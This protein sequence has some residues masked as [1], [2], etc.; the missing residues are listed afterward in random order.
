[1]D[2]ELKR[3]RLKEM[4]KTALDCLDG[5]LSARSKCLTITTHEYFSNLATI[6][7][8][9]LASTLIEGGWKCGKGCRGNREMGSILDSGLRIKIGN[10]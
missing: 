7:I 10:T 9:D 4:E 1:M 6:L 8:I 5:A 3:Q 2:S